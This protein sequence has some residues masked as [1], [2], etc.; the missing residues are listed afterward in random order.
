MA[1]NE[2]LQ[3]KYRA[4]YNLHPEIGNIILEVNTLDKK[5]T[6]YIEE[7]SEYTNAFPDV[8][9][10]TDS[11]LLPQS[12]RVT[13]ESG[14]YHREK[15]IVFVDLSLNVT[16]A[17]SANNYWPVLAG[18]PHPKKSTAIAVST[19]ARSGVYNAYINTNGVITINTG[20]DALAS[21]NKLNLTGFYFI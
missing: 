21:G 5:V 1:D 18:L 6:T 10:L 8:S 2:T 4:G 19:G 13:I 12:G 11:G 3:E 17:M 15:T 9:D 7:G 16:A 20:N 14:G